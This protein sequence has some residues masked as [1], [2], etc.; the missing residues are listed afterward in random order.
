MKSKK[1][2]RKR[3]PRIKL[4]PG[5]LDAMLAPEIDLHRVLERWNEAAQAD[6]LIIREGIRH[7][8][9]RLLRHGIA[10]LVDEL[11][12]VLGRLRRGTR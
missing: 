12:Q 9:A 11:N 5:V 4:E 6:D 8:D 1:K 10:V 7:S 3:S 2:P